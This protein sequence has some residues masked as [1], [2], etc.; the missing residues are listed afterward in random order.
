MSRM[1][2]YIGI[3]CSGATIAVLGF[4]GQQS[5]TGLPV[6]GIIAFLLC[7][8]ALLSFAFFLYRIFL[9]Y[10]ARYDLVAEISQKFFM[11]EASL[12]DILESYQRLRSVWLFRLV[13]WAPFLLL[14][15][16]FVAGALAMLGI[17]PKLTPIP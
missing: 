13:F 9:I 6:L 10:S 8:T 1:I 15:F 2:T 3:A 17:G 11:R 12:E 16:G 7:A 4:L 5:K 14:T